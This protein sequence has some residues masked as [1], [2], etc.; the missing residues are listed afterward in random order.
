MHSGVFGEEPWVLLSI[1]QEKGV[2]I[3]IYTLECI[4]YMWWYE[5][6]MRILK[7]RGGTEDENHGP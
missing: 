1:S 5:W 2:E 7:K 4:P 6:K 3:D